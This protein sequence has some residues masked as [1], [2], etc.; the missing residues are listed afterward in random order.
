MEN[1]FYIKSVLMCQ[2]LKDLLTPNTPPA[3]SDNVR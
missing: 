1:E 3:F 2:Y